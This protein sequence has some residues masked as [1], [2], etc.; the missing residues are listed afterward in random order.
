MS[1]N[2]PANLNLNSPF[3][4]K[5][6]V[7]TITKLHGLRKVVLSLSLDVQCPFKYKNPFLVLCFMFYY[8]YQC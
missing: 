5:A 6:P 2:S 7:V 4:F 3:L 8:Q 1:D